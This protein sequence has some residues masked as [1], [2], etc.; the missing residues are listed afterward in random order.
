[1]PTSRI[2]TPVIFS[3]T[4][5]ALMLRKAYKSNISSALFCITVEINGIQYVS[6]NTENDEFTYDGRLTITFPHINITDNMVVR[7][8]FEDEYGNTSDWSEFYL[9]NTQNDKFSVTTTN[10]DN[11]PKLNSIDVYVSDNSSN[12]DTYTKIEIED[13]TSRHHMSMNS[14]LY[15]YPEGNILL[16]TKSFADIIPDYVDGE[17]TYRLRE[18]DLHR[19]DRISYKFYGTPELWWVIAAVNNIIDPFN[20]PQENMALRILPLHYVEYALLRYDINNLI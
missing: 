12:G 19:F 9:I 3:A 18:N 10:I 4:L 6:Y 5:H 2:D 11:I 13:N 20:D 15:Q 14:Y 1:M 16:A 8:K 7:L 17:E